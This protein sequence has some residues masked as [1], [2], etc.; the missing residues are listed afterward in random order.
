[1]YQEKRNVERLQSMNVLFEIQRKKELTIN[2]LNKTIS[3]YKQ[4]LINTQKNI[5]KCNNITLK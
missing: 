5:I 3:N 2:T 4:E 1:M